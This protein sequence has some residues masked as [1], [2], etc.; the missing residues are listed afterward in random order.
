MVLVGPI[1]RLLTA[2]RSV[3]QNHFGGVLEVL[4][5]LQRRVQSVQRG[6]I[7][8]ALLAFARSL[9]LEM[10]CSRKRAPVPEC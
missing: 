5:A 10:S 7:S 1:H 2:W 3:E 4:W 6:R 9:E 8:I